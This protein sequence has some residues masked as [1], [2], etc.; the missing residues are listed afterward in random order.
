MSDQWKAKVKTIAGHP[1]ALVDVTITRTLLIDAEVYEHISHFLSV[2]EGDHSGLKEVDDFFKLI[3][4]LPPESRRF[5][6]VPWTDAESK[7]I[8][9]QSFATILRFFENRTYWRVEGSAAEG[10]RGYLNFG[11]Q[12]HSIDLSEGEIPKFQAKIN[13]ARQEAD[14]AN[15]NGEITQD[16]LD[17]IQDL[18]KIMFDDSVNL[19]DLYKLYRDMQRERE[20]Q[21]RE[22]LSKEILDRDRAKND[23]AEYRG[24][25]P[26]GWGDKFGSAA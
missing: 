1:V 16:E 23:G 2:G 17:R 21:E 26:A 14:K 6:V 4:Q 5:V 22:H 24:D 20:S 7:K 11:S 18:Y 25:F 12:D 3:N 8:G 9:L 10:F 19:Y 15:S 13:E